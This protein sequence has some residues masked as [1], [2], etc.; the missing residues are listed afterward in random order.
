M[1]DMNPPKELVVEAENFEKKVLIKLDS[2]K[3][4]DKAEVITLTGE[5]ELVHKP[6]VNTREK[7]WVVPESRKVTVK[8]NVL[9]VVLPANSVNVVV[10]SRA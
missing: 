10:F 8:D 5:A 6:N 7:E 9:P 3:V 2:L 4:A 1:N